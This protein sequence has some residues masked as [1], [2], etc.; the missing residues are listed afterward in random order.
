[1]DSVGEV[2]ENFDGGVVSVDGVG[3]VDD[4]GKGKMDGIIETL[5]PSYKDMVQRKPL[6][7]FTVTL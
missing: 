3:P 1:V 4:I 6:S 5:V 7:V 2:I